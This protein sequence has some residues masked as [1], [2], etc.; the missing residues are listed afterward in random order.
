[1]SKEILEEIKE[2]YT[3]N[4]NPLITSEEL[5]DLMR[6]AFNK[7]LEIAAESVKVRTTSCGDINQCGCMGRCEA[8]YSYVDKASILKNKI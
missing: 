2:N 3:W 4:S 8:P 5:D 1:M 6:L 7:A